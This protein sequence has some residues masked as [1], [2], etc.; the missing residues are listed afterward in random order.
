MEDKTELNDFERRI[1][2]QVEHANANDIDFSDC[3]PLNVARTVFGF[4]GFKENGQEKIMNVIAW[5]LGM[6]IGS[7]MFFIKRQIDELPYV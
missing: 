5:L 7:L 3:T 2:E 1:I 4:N 6:V